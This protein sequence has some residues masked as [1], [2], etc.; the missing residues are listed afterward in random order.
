MMLYDLLSF[1]KSLP[2]HTILSASDT[3]ALEPSLVQEGLSG[4]AV[5]YD[6][7]ANSPERLCIENLVD[8]RAHGAL[9]FNYSEV[10][11]SQKKSRTWRVDFSRSSGNVKRQ[12]CR[13]PVG[14]RRS[15][16]MSHQV[17][18]RRF[19]ITSVVFMVREPMR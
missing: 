6:A 4:A 15:K 14:G 13:Y 5:Y 1:D 10:V 3:L 17:S 2:G 9:L 16:Q 12:L 18:G 8:A 7:Q 19:L 11:R